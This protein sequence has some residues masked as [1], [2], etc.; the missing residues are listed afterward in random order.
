MIP[1]AAIGLSDYVKPDLM[2]G[3][4]SVEHQHHPSVG[5]L[6]GRELALAGYVLAIEA[7]TGHPVDYGVAIYI[8]LNGESMLGWRVVRIDDSLRRA[9]LDA[10]DRIALILEHP[11]EPPQPPDQCPQTCPYFE[12]CR[13]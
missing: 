4:I 3:F 2:V 8:N 6:R 1:A 11:E 13:R 9:F 7:W 5:V 12:V 10:R